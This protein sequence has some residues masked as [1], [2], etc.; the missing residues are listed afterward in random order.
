MA[1]E[2]FIPKF[3][4]TYDRQ[5]RLYPGLLVVAPVAVLLVC[6]YGTEH[7]IVSS[8]LSILG[9]CGIAYALGRVARDAGKRL[10]DALFVKWGGA[11]TTQLLR[12]RDT[13][14]DIH[15]KERFRGVLTEGLK[16]P[17]PTTESEGDNPAAADEL[18][19]AAIVWL[20]DQTRDSKEFPLVFKENV[21]FGFHRNCLGIRRYGVVV[22][23][24]C[25]TWVLA[26]ARV[27]TTAPPYFFSKRVL[28][29]DFGNAVTL[30]VSAVMLFA[31]LFLLNEGALKRA[32]FSYAERLLQACDR[33]KPVPHL[34]KT[35]Q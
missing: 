23:V 5:A 16:T 33:L 20:I 15:T 4:D 35:H 24:A 32:G 6:L 11:P 25:A 34:T 10:Q 12:Y 14:F 30:G 29:L 2:G 7:I 17:L 22:A 13:H 21:A 1:L 3:M 26:Y 19:R 28:S 18:Y 9:F 31:W 8:V 27:L